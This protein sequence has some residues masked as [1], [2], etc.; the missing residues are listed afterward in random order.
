MT[1]NSAAK[2]FHLIDDMEK[3]YC[4]SIAARAGDF[5]FIG[6]LTATDNDGNELYADDPGMQM[7]NVYEKMGRILDEHGGCSGDIVSETI[8]YDV[9]ASVYETLMFP[10]RQKFYEA[11][12]GPS[13]AGVQVA[14]FLSPAI[15]VEVTAIAYLPQQRSNP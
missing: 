7:K 6:G 15:K 4:M 8:F 11:V 12:E 3:D 2:F 1:S 14:G 10:H 5:L 9:S 13:V